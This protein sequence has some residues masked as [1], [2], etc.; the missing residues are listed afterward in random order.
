MERIMAFICLLLWFPMGL[1][2][3]QKPRLIVRADDLGSFASANQ[4]ILLTVDQGITTS[5]ELMMNCAWTPEALN[6]LK[7]YPNL[8]VGVHLMITSEWDNYKWRPLTQAPSISDSLGFFYSFI[9]P[10]L[11]APGRAIQEH[12]WNLADIE[13]EF[14]AQIEMAKATVPQV[15]HISTHMLCGIWDEDVKTMLD[16]LAKEYK[17]PQDFD[18][19][20]ELFPIDSFDKSAELQTKISRFI[21]AL[22]LLEPTKTYL[23]VEHPG[24]DVDEMETVGH[25]G[26]RNVRK[27]RSDIT[28]ILTHPLVRQKI[29]DLGIELTDFKQTRLK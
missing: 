22:D 8:D 25:E 1:N 21:D 18:Y 19:N 10:N 23:F 13:R 14:R 17:L 9:N 11:L 15:S 28:K 6:L 27:D 12:P 3:Q 4:A 2:A 7:E 24:L 16:R 5:V 29:K 26:Y 20:I